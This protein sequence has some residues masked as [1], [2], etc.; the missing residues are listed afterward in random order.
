MRLKAVFMDQWH[1]PVRSRQVDLGEIVTGTDG[2]LK[3]KDVK[4]IP[5]TVGAIF[6]KIEEAKEEADGS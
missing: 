3:L 5:V 1:R 4:P 6:V 2:E